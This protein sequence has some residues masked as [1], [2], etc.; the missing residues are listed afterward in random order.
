MSVATP[1]VWYE[2]VRPRDF[3]C[4][5][6]LVCGRLIVNQG[7]DEFNSRMQRQKR[8]QML[9]NR[10][11]FFILLVRMKVQVRDGL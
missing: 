8:E 4:M 9:L 6:P 11:T 7:R 10:F 3:C 2:T 5:G 1:T